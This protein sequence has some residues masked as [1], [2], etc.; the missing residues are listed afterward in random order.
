MQRASI[1]RNARYIG[2]PPQSDGRGPTAKIW[3]LAPR[4]PSRA[5]NSVAEPRT[6]ARPRTRT[7]IAPDGNKVKNQC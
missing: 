3:A 4:P 5:A 2:A 1:G 6:V 7:W